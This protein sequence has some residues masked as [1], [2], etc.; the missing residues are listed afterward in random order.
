ME[1]DR[2]I[3]IRTDGNE[4]IASGHLVRCLTIAEAIVRQGG[5][6][7]FLVSDETSRKEL[8]QRIEQKTERIQ[9]LKPF[10][11]LVLG[12]DYRK[13]EQELPLLE[14]IFS[15]EKNSLLLL[16][17]YF[18]TPEYLESL[19]KMTRVFYLDDLQLFDYPVDGVINY[20]L[21]VDAGFYQSAR[22]R[23]LEGKYAPLREQFR[24]VDYRVRERA[25]DLLLTT[26]GTDPTGFCERFLTYFFAQPDALQWNVHVVVGSMFTKK[27]TLAQMAAGRKNLFLYQNVSDM[28]ELM[29]KCDL[30]ISA[31][32]TTLFELCAVGV[33][34][35]SI[36]VSENQLPCNR[37]FEH[38]GLISY[39]GEAWREDLPGHLYAK[40]MEIGSNLS[41]RQAVS[42]R[43][44]TA[45]DGKGADRIAEILL[46]QS[47]AVL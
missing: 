43:Q 14:R 17:S 18:V 11:I 29:K 31:G 6:V 32:G 30:A 47:G 1:H 22:H 45:I 4:R 28:A 5:S 37:A 44:R 12:T 2:L 20:D 23:Y 19:K 39:E 33:P 13:P 21:K 34:A 8:Q 24:D 9:G 40:V 16:D 35:L 27:Q 26:G 7:K 36:S 10:E 25:K 15:G 41:W 3:Y 46:E 38:A 42:K